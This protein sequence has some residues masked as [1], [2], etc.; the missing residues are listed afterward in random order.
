VQLSRQDEDGLPAILDRIAVGL[1]SGALAAF[2]RITADPLAQRAAP[3]D[4]TA[5]RRAAV[6]LARRFGIPLID[7]PP[8]AGFSWDGEAL[9]IRSEAYVLMHEVAHWQ[10]CPA[11]RLGLPDFGLGAGPE[12]GRQAEAD[13][14]RRVDPETELLEEQRSS[15]LGILW[16]AALCQ[17]A[18]NAFLEQNWLE[19][20]ERGAAAA[21]FTRIL[22]DLVR[23][24]LATPEGLPLAVTVRSRA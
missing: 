18:L 20:W 16:E 8:M 17:P 3:Y 12:T 11:E 19:G 21:H 13:A 24:G 2:R 15:L 5:H 4:T 23:L 7:E 6:D 10:L 22:S 9:R 14:A 1:R